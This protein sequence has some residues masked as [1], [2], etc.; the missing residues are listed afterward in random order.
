MSLTNFPNGITSFGVPVLGGGG[1]I[2][3]TGKKFFVDPVNG[4]DG[5]KGTEP[6]RA[7]ATLYKAYAMCTDGANDVVYLISDGTATS[8]ARLSKALAQSVNS[9]ATTGT[10]TWAKDACHL[11]G[12]TS[13]SVNPRARIAPPTGTYTQATF[14]SGD[15]LSVTASGCYFANISLFHGF[16]TGGANQICLNMTGG[17]NVFENCAFGGAGDAASAQATTS[18]SV[19]IT[20]SGENKF[21]DCT[22]GLDTVTRTVANASLD[23]A[24]ATVRNEFINCV[25]PFQ[26]SAAGVLGIL[27]TGNGA[28]DRWQL[29]DR[30]KFINNI[31]SLSTQM[32]VLAS[33]T[34]A[35]AGGMLVFKDCTVVGITKFGDTNALAI[36]YIEGGTPTAATTGLA[37]NPS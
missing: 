24:G 4:S 3:F 5:N 1:A 7:F 13:P 17:R 14:G 34:T 11:I 30:C 36:S 9:A 20:G 37:V 29:F 33:A 31:A 25:F 15:F 18:R 10:L 35:A 21:I 23:L 12:I 6:K 8:T 28:I 16:S 27:A 2:P 19:K 26:T 32:T 22:I